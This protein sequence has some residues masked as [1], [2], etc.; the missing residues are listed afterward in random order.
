[1]LITDTYPGI[2]WFPRNRLVAAVMWLY[3]RVVG[4]PLLRCVDKVVLLHEGLTKVAHRYRL[5]FEVI[6]NGV[7]LEVADAAKPAPDLAKQPGEIWI[8]YVGRLESVK[9][10][11]YLLEAV[12]AL[13]HKHPRVKTLFVGASLPRGLASSDRVRFLGFRQDVYAVL[14]HCDIFCLPSLS[15]GLP[16]SLMEAMASGCACVASNVGGVVYLL[17][18]AKNGL[19]VAPGDLDG[20]RDALEQLIE[21]ANLRRSLAKEARRTI[22]ERFN[23]SKIERSYEELFERVLKR[24]SPGSVLSGSSELEDVGATRRPG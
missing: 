22:E 21:D 19:L 23:W 5:D 7:D 6:H 20:L 16:N 18:Q 10:Y 17:E 15:E 14:K 8:G 9:G 3:A 13:K 1:L 12:E 4:I 11:D 2:N 24:S